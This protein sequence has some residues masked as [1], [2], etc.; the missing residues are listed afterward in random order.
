MGGLIRSRNIV[1]AANK[2]GIAM[3]I[4]AQVGETSLLTRAA[5]SIAQYIKAN[6]LAQEGAFGT[7]LLDRDIV[8]DALMFGKSGT[9]STDGLDFNKKPGFGLLVKVLEKDL[10]TLC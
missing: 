9:L 7:Y 2:L 8:S 3:I 4:G 6:L 1:D 10:L 5:L